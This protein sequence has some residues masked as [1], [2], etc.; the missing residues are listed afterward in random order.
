MC[1][2]NCVDV[3]AFHQDYVLPEISF[4]HNPAFSCTVVMHIDALKL[5]RFA[6]N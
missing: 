3:V 5:N 1:G 6:V 4:R 2:A